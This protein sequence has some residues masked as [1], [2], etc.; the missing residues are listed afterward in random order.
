MSSPEEYLLD[1]QQARKTCWKELE[2]IHS[3]LVGVEIT[4]KELKLQYKEAT[5][6]YQKADYDLALVDGRFKK[7]EE[8][9]EQTRKKKVVDTQELISR[10]SEK[11]I[12]EILA[13]LGVKLPEVE[14]VPEPSEVNLADVV[15]T[16][17]GGE[18]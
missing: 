2:R 6:R 13:E 5:V 16:E 4:Y 8:A 12:E 14:E 18:N 7:V 17:E 11:E 15:E 3:M 9:G 1:L 10:L